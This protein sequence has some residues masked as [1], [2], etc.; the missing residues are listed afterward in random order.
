M[1]EILW[2]TRSNQLVWAAYTSYQNIFPYVSSGLQN[3][4]FSYKVLHLQTSE[5]WF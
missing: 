4:A 1:N 3:P 2:V 5:A